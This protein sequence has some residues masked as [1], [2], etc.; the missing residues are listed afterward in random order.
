MIENLIDILRGMLSPELVTIFVAMLPI[1]ELRGALP[2]AITIFKMEPL[3]AYGLSVL[4]N[5]VPVIPILLILDPL[6]KWLSRRSSIFKRFFDWLFE[7]TRR[8]GGAVEK[9]EALGLVLFVA[10]PLPITGAWTGCIA[11][12][13]FG[14]RF[15]YAL[16]AISAGILI[17]GIVVGLASLGL[18]NLWGIL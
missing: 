8:R 16:P 7:R 17:A 10:I 4:G 15:R 11:S 2:I 14:I 5:M 13:I 9:Y 6:S 3:K 1:A 18:I 12:L